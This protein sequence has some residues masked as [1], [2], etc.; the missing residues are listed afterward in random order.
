L[1]FENLKLLDSIA[2]EYDK[3]S[4]ANT[5]N[6]SEKLQLVE[7]VEEAYRK[8][9]RTRGGSDRRWEQAPVQEAKAETEHRMRN[10]KAAGRPRISSGH[11]AKG[12]SAGRGTRTSAG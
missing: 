7:E 6:N 3:K 12:D 2:Q 9:L 4:P 10:M 5:V 11:R 1:E 8:S